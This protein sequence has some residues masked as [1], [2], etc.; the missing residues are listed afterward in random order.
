MALHDAIQTDARFAPLFPPELDIVLW[1]VRASTAREA[2]ALARRV[3][4]VAAK[5]DLHLALATIPRAMAEPAAAVRNWDADDILCLRACVMKPEHREW[6]PEIL[7][8]LRV[9]ADDLCGF[10]SGS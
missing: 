3:F 9:A 1:A 10:R 5:R 8:R 2:S 7:N 6:M 4:D